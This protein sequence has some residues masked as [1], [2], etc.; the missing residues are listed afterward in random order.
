[1]T[2]RNSLA[3]LTLA[4]FGITLLGL[5]AWVFAR[6]GGTYLLHAN[7]PVTSINLRSENDPTGLGIATRTDVLRECD[8][9]LR[10]AKSFELMVLSSVKFEDLRQRCA[11]IS[12]DIAQSAP[13]FSLDWAVA[14]R[15]AAVGGDWPKMNE[16]FRASQQTGPNEQWI[17]RL[18]FEMADVFFDQLDDISR[19]AYDQDL[20]MLIKSNKGIPYIARQYVLDVAF[21][22]R[23]TAVLESMSETDQ[24]RYV[25]IL[26]RM[27]PR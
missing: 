5:G 11:Q 26:R 22:A 14:A 6:E 25:S 8:S 23:I 9:T 20:A 24:R 16:Y 7:T 18:R 17:G 15:A 2:Q 4:V 13:T 3:A 12:E 21:R 19:S 27:I 1:V 10:S